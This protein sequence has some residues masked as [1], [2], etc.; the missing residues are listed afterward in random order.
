MTDYYVISVIELRK[1]YAYICK[2]YRKGINDILFKRCLLIGI[3]PVFI[4][5]L[6]IL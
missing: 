6:G 1:K 4:K 5:L 3:K 2:V